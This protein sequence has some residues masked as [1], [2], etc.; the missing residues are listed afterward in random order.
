MAWP[1][2]IPLALVGGVLMFPFILV[3]DGLSFG[4]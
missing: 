1:T 3:L 4:D 2:T